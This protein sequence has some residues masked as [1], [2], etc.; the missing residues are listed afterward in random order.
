MN[1]KQKRNLKK[2]VNAYV[3][4]LPQLIGLVVFGALPII[5]VFV[6]SFSEW[7][8]IGSM[9][10]VGFKSIFAELKHPYFTKAMS[11]TL[12]FVIMN[13]PL[14]VGSAFIIAM[15]LNNVRFKVLFRA[16]YFMP[17]VTS[18][19]ASVMVWQWLFHPDFG[20]INAVLN[21][22]F[23]LPVKILWLGSTKTAML[24]IVIMN[25]WQTL[26]YGLILFLAGLQAVPGVYYEAATIDGAN[27]W[28][29]TR[30]ITVPLLSPTTFYCVI[31]SIIGSF[32]VFGQPYLLT[33]GGPLR[34]T[35][36][37]AM[38]IFQKGFTDMEMGRACAVSL[39][40][41]VI[42]II[43]TG[44]QFRVSKRWVFYEGE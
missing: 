6:I 30:M 40:L 27:K 24:S 31:T 16:I 4:L 19:V 28:Q 42:I 21:G 44:I 41:F 1:I 38:H 2:N 13:V 22:V 20:P 10:F 26:G 17:V 14:T 34:S 12:V 39:V 29:K 25:A 3:L 36:T 32:Q 37:I 33:Q 8:L 5:M 18:V 15:L 35:Y 9:H 43:I 7:N 11:N 23:H